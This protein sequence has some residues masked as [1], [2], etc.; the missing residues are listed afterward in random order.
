[1]RLQ[2]IA[3]DHSNETTRGTLISGLNEKDIRLLDVFEGD[4]YTRKPVEIAVLSEACKISD[5]SSAIADPTKRTDAEE[6]RTVAAETYIWTTT[7]KR[8]HQ[9]AWK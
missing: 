6:I 5:L 2:P 3:T 4:E 9:K 1:M 7:P 8:L